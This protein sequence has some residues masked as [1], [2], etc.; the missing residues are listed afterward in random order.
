VVW[1]M[2]KPFVVWLGTTPFAVWLGQSTDR[3]AWLFVFHLFGLTIFLGTTVLLS[4]RLLG[5]AMTAETVSQLSRELGRWNLFGLVLMLL[6]GGLIFIGGA[7][8]YFA[9]DWFRTKMEFLVVALI[10]RFS[11][12]AMVMHAEEGR[13]APL[14]NKLA[15]FLSLVLWFGVALSGRAIAFFEFG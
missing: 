10:F 9:G 5:I 8:T 14:L 6:S 11:L 4:L 15:G 3:I 2:L 7:E 13:F 1:E 12:F